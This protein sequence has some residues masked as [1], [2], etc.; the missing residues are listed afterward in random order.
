MSD[1]FKITLLKLIWLSIERTPYG[2]TGNLKLLFQPNNFFIYSKGRNRSR[3][4]NCVKASIVTIEA[5]R[6]FPKVTFN[7]TVD[8]GVHVG[9]R[10]KEMVAETRAPGIFCY[11]V[12]F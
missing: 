7:Q 3:A 12:K 1:Y 6:L 2:V 9:E 10:D 8:Q 11:A 5:A 4:N